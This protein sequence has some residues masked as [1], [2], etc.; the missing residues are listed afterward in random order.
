MF[1]G[2]RHVVDPAAVTTTGLKQD[3]H[4][5][6]LPALG[7]RGRPGIY[8]TINQQYIFCRCFQVTIGLKAHL[9]IVGKDLVFVQKEPF[10]ISCCIPGFNQFSEWF[11]VIGIITKLSVGLNEKRSIGLA[12]FDV[13]IVAG[14]HFL[15]IIKYL[16][17]GG[18]QCRDLFRGMAPLP[19]GEGKL[20]Q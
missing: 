10:H 8:G 18:R 13:K 5:R 2:L 7:S 3:D 11:R 20:Q 9:W 19:E 6:I 17:V 1:Q 16:L 14:A 12:A 15:E 4:T